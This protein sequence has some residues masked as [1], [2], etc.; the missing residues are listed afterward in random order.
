MIP[1]GDHRKA[2]SS[3]L[4]TMGWA[5]G[6][7]GCGDVSGPLPTDLFLSG[8]PVLRAFPSFSEPQA[9][10]LLDTNRTG[11]YGCLSGI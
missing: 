2:E 6:S 4:G 11:L 10:S 8:E 5:D 3:W 1:G 7:L 9:C